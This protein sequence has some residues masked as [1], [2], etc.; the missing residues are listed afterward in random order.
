MQYGL[1]DVKA[2]NATTDEYVDKFIPF[3]ISKEI[4]KFLQSVLS[5]YDDIVLKAKVYERS[6]LKD[7]YSYL[8]KQTNYDTK[9]LFQENMT[10]LKETLKNDIESIDLMDVRNH[11]SLK[12]AT[13][14][15]QAIEV[16]AGS[17]EMNP[18]L[19]L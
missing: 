19:S 18:I 2:M 16:I 6:K 7:L 10:N 9:V 13:S 4:S 17:T 15:L 3:R 5:D 14:L 12:Q 8:C 11:K 1:E